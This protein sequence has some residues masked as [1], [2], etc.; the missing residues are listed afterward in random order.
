MTGRHLYELLIQDCL[1]VET[2]AACRV[3]TGIRSKWVLG[4][5]RPVVRFWGAEYP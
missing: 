4:W 1:C 3:D 5:H 2:D